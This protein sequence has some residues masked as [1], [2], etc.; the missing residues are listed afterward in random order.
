MSKH[1]PSIVLRQILE[2]AEEILGLIASTETPR[3][4]ENRL[5]ELAVLRL[6]EMTGEAATRLP[7]DVIGK[8][9]QVPWGQI[10]GLRNRLIHGYDSV[11]LEVVEQIIQK[12][13]PDLIDKLRAVLD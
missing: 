9:P 2:H 5:L 1:D 3:L 6:L 11:D 4:A 10:V 8:H 13:L 7:E 12:D